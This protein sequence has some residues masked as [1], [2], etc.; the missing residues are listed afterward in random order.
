MSSETCIQI[1]RISKLEKQVEELSKNNK[2]AHTKIYDRL[3]NLNVE[4]ARSD[5]NQKHVM[6]KLDTM[7]AKIE[8]T[9]TKLDEIMSQPI[10]RY[11]NVVTVIITVVVTALLT[12]VIGQ[13]L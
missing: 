9:N 7:D 11:D 3:D 12:F 1:E 8:K 13:I 6:A 10:K 5:E 2:E 4:H